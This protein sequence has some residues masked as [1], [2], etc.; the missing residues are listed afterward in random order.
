MSIRDNTKKRG[1]P[2]TTG[3]GQLIGVRLLQEPLSALDAWI[4]AQAD[5]KPSR[6][7][8]IRQIVIAHLRRRGLLAK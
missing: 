3:T 2:R 5:P 1:R 7:E 8:A 4:E 6:P